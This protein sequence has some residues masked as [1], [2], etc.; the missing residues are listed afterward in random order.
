M[1]RHAVGV[2]DRMPL[3]V[4]ERQSLWRHRTMDGHKKVSYPSPMD[5]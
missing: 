4:Q 1:N 5:H 2:E 3:P